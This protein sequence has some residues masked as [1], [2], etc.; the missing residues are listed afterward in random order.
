MRPS[1]PPHRGHR[2]R[3]VGPAAA[4]LAAALLAAVIV[5]YR[6][7]VAPLGLHARGV[8][9]AAARAQVLIDTKPSEI[10]S[11]STASQAQSELGAQLALSYALY[12]QSDGA[13]AAIGR[14]IGL[15]QAS[16][17]AS[18]P[19]TLLLN[20]V[21]YARQPP[22]LP[23]PQRV[24]H[25]YR[26]LLD[27]DGAHPILSL[28]AQAPTVQAAVAIADDARRLLEHQV[29]GQEAAN[30]PPRKAAV[31]LRP[32]GATTGALAA[33]E[34][35]WQLMALTFVGVLLL[36]GSF[37]W[38][39]R[40]RR[41]RSSANRVAAAELDR[42]DDRPE[43]SDDWPHTRRLLPWAIAA[44]IAMLFLVPIDAIELPVH[45]PINSHLDRPF[46]IAL[47]MLWIASLAVVS[48]AARPRLKLG[49]VHFT[50]LVFLAVC[51]LSV[52]LNAQL[53]AN[54][55]DVTEAVKKLA[56]LISYIFFF[57]IAASVVRPREVPRFAVML[58]ALGVIVAVATITEYRT[59]YNVFYSLWEKVL[60][61]E[62]PPEFD[63][64][65]DIGRLAVYGPTVQPLELAAMLAMVLPFAILGMIDAPTRGRRVLYV[66]AFGLLLGAGLATGR[67][68]SVVVP[69]V[70]LLLL[71]A[72]RPRAIARKLGGLCVVIF[73]I[74][75][76]AAP[77]AIGSLVSELEPGHVNT[78]LTTTARV[79]RYDAVA[80]DIL[81]HPVIG[82]G[83]GSYDAVKNRILDNQYLD[84]AITVGVIGTLCY[85]VM[86]GA[87]M[88]AAHR[89][90]RG[91]DPKRASLA[92]AGAATVASAAVASVLFD[93]LYFPHVPYLLFFVAAMIV[94]LRE[95]SPT[96]EPA[97]I[98]ARRPLGRAGP[99]AGGD[100]PD[101]ATD[102][103]LAPRQPAPREPILA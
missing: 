39:W 37:M 10:G 72:Y 68:T 96:H 45:L 75:H 73:V 85:A 66:I 48:G 38:A 47:A 18:G 79:A 31:V 41:I 91:P 23:N 65:D 16:I 63:K 20:Q 4:L 35:R 14:E 83:Y 57:F 89:T 100:H 17:A 103:D 36:G 97:G 24:D 74:V 43:R 15:G 32:L 69:T 86:L 29:A 94:A 3:R 13:T 56:L 51:L 71:T 9:L 26:L 22:A 44:F 1:A 12:L 64:V 6:P 98:I 102:P 62:R 61:V 11:T 46:L 60:P 92:L 101:P 49:S 95:P 8:Q 25:S 81:S 30:P 52:A 21:N 34:P 70:A 59:H 82:R 84:L 40:R 67:K 55:D 42:L 58:V 88:V 87:M 33:R 80:P 99:R 2:W 7:S 78:A 77:Q 50:A 53:L 5:G 28:Y 76:F 54:M 27:L 90:I 19:F 93:V